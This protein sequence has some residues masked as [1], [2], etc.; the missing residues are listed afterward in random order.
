MNKHA[1]KQLSE[2][3]CIVEKDAAEEI[4]EEDIQRIEQL[5]SPPMY[6]T[7]QMLSKLRDSSTDVEEDMTEVE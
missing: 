2:K 6:I 3:G 7:E 5:E 4:T 1:V